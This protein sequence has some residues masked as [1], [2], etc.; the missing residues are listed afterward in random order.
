MKLIWAIILG[1]FLIFP[2]HGLILDERGTQGMTLLCT[3]SMQ[4][5]FSCKNNLTLE[6]IGYSHNY[7]VGD[8]VAYSPTAQQ[9][10]IGIRKGF[11][12]SNMGFVLHRLVAI[13][14]DSMFLM[15]DANSFVDNDY[16]GNISA[17]QIRYKVVKIA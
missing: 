4:P 11:Q 7:S 16:I 5:T 13:Q 3:N 12:L 9:R 8:I 6:F 2:V 10:Y 1:I 15:G 17:Y 14:G